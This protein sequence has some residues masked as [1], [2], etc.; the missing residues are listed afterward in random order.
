M[1][2]HGASTADW[3]AFCAAAVQ[4]F[5]ADTPIRKITSAAPHPRYA[6]TPVTSCFPPARSGDDA[7]SPHSTGSV[8]ALLYPSV[9]GP[10]YVVKRGKTPVLEAEQART[11]P[12]SNSLRATTLSADAA[13]LHGDHPTAIIQQR[14][15]AGLRKPAQKTFRTLRA[16]LRIRRRGV[17]RKW[18]YLRCLHLF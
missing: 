9:R 2:R 5:H 8:I 17:A 15:R 10:K 14:G 16:T 1:L 6:R 12:R 4:V 18:R 7:S 13:D 11:L 3:Q